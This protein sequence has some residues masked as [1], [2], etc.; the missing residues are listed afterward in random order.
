M[1]KFTVISV[2]LAGAKFPPV[3][4]DNEFEAKELLAEQVTEMI[5]DGRI[6]L[7]IELSED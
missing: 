5:A 7:D 2:S 1:A 4:A 3:E 6:D